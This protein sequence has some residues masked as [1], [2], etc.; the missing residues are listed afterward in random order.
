MGS[1]NDGV[2]YKLNKLKG[3]D[4]DSK[5]QRPWSYDDIMTFRELLVCRRMRSE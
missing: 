3:G 5:A 1:T 4:G 2:Y